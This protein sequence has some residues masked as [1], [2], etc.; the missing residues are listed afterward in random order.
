MTPDQYT[1]LC[2]LYALGDLQGPERMEFE[3]HLAGCADCREGLQQ[4]VELNE[5]IFSAIPRVQPSA[6]LRRRV[7]AGFGQAAKTPRKSFV[8]AYALVAAAAVILTIAAWSSEHKRR[9]ENEKELARLREIQQILQAPSTKEVTFGP[10]PAEP[11]G[12]IFV[13]QKLGILLI[14]SS[15]P[16]PP[17]GWTYESWVLPKDGAPVPI[18]SFR[19]PDGRGIS[20]LQTKLPVD[21][22]KAV[23]VSLEPENEPVTKP[24]KVIFAAPLG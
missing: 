8:W 15:L 23:A 16:T 2:E 14:A 7:L 12:N 6:Q 5:M 17:S 13:H 11:H 19:A 24:T 22:L 4:A 3:Q 21:Q 1:D 9:V 18:E 20:L 10:Q